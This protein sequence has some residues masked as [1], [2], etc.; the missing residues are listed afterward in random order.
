MQAEQSLQAGDLQ[1]ALT[2]LQDQVR[3]NPANVQYRVFLFQLLAVLGQWERAFTQL[4]VLGEMDAGTLAMVKTYQAALSCEALRAEVFAGQRTP[5]LFGQPEQWMALLIEALRLTA[6]G[7]GT[8]AQTMR[9]Q[10]FAAAPTTNGTLDGQPFEWIAD[11][12][13]RLGPMLEAII[14]GRYYWVPFAHIRT[15]RIE[16]PTDLRDLVWLPATF[17][18]ANGGEVV[19]FIPTR[20]PD[21]AHSDDAMLR[22][23][24]KTEWQE[25]PG[26]CYVG[27]GQR[28]LATDTGEYPLLDCRLI[29]LA[30][31]A[32]TDG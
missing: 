20:Y 10:A 15:L 11:A 26:D 31:S 6:T 22:L 18:W 16:Q 1:G 29:E 21:S 27:L 28:L 3:K 19:G 4:K 17:I 25:R 13:M 23:S 2:Q 24:R 30:T 9:E 12:D 32:A 7:A 8:E 14:N 5:L